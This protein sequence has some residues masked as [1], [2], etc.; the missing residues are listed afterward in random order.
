MSQAAENHLPNEPYVIFF[1]Q[2]GDFSPVGGEKQ[3]TDRGP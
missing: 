3:P 1:A 2:A